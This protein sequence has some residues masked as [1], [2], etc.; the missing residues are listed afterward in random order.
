MVGPAAHAYHGE[1]SR[2]GSRPQKQKE[3]KIE[4]NPAAEITGRQG[5]T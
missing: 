4:I 5:V 2:D 1:K 3:T